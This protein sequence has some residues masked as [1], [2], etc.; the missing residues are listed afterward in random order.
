MVG[1][2]ASDDEY[3]Y[4]LGI[5]DQSIQP[6]YDTANGVESWRFIYPNGML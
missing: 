2:W 4:I 5:F 3:C 6:D 1:Q